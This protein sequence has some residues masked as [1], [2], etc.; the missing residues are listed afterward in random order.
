MASKPT[1]TSN[2]NGRVAAA[3]FTSRFPKGSVGQV[4]HHSVKPFATLFGDFASGHIGEHYRGQEQALS[5]PATG[6]N[7]RSFAEKETEYWNNESGLPGMIGSSM[8]AQTREGMLN[9][10]KTKLVKAG[11]FQGDE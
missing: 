2:P 5:E 3:D 9:C 4:V 7:I 11:D 1:V 6:P 8:G 10:T